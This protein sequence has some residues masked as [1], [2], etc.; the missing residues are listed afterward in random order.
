MSSTTMRSASPIR[1]QQEME[2]ALSPLQAWKEGR[3]YTAAA[4]TASLS[5]CM[6]LRPQDHAIPCSIYTAAAAALIHAVHAGRAVS[7]TANAPVYHHHPGHGTAE[8]LRRLRSRAWGQNL[9]Q[10]PRPKVQPTSVSEPAQA[11][12]RHKCQGCVLGLLGSTKARAM[13][14]GCMTLQAP[15]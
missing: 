11:W 6:I 9:G 7:W 5:T 2:E 3:P 8:G 12:D 14:M 4:C 15:G 13:R 10:K 1:P